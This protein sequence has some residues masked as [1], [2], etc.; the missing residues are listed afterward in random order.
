MRKEM[1]EKG[2]ESKMR[3]DSQ[4]IKVGKSKMV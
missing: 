3:N 2:T 4:E 1:G